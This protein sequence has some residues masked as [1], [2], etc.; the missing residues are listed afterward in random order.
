MPSDSRASRLAFWIVLLAMSA[1]VVG[2]DA[3]LAH[4]RARR[5]TPKSDTNCG[6]AAAAPAAPAPSFAAFGS[7]G[8]AAAPPVKKP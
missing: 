6:T 1:A 3:G 5:T 2:L 8:D 7:C 4:A